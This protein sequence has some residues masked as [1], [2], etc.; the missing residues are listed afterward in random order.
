LEAKAKAH[1]KEREAL[2]DQFDAEKRSLLDEL[3]IKVGVQAS[4]TLGVQASHS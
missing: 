1:D 2:L 3:D 4:F